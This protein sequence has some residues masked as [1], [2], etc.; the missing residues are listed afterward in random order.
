M[1]LFRSA[2]EAVQNTAKHAQATKIL[3]RLLKEKDLWLLAVRDDGFGLPNDT[4]E[5]EGVGLRIM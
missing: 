2:Q 5:S 1:Q 4:P 3:I